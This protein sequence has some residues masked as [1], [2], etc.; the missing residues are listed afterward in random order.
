MVMVQSALFKYSP[1]DLDEE[2]KIEPEPVELDFQE[3]K[4]DAVLLMDSYFTV[5]V[6]FGEDIQSWK[7]RKVNEDP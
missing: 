3:M 1:D 2:G 7:E 4:S 6:W 5:I